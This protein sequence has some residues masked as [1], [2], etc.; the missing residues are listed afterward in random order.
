MKNLVLTAIAA[1]LVSCTQ[2]PPPAPEVSDMPEA[3]D[4]AALAGQAKRYFVGGG[5]IP[6]DVEVTVT[7][8]GAFE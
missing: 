6:A 5:Q 3:P 8:F 4:E 7:A 1:L 2:A